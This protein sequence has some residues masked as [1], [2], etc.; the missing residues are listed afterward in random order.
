MKLNR[1]YFSIILGAVLGIACIIGVSLRIGFSGNELFII[2]TWYNRVI[3]GLVIGLLPRAKKLPIVR[4]AFMGLIISL[5]LA[6]PTNFYDIPG[7]FAGIAYGIIIDY[8]ASK[9]YK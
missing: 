5:S 9:K 3:M 8:F 4:G 2:G 7:F 1:L 6:L